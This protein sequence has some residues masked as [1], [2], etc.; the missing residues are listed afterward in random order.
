MSKLSK[1]ALE[2]F[3]KEGIRGG[4][5]GAAARNKNLTPEERTELAKKAAAARWAKKPKK[6]HSKKPGAMQ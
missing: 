5:L 6:V 1:A 3:R 2:F 4:K